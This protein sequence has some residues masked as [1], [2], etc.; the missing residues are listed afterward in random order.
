MTDS[1][2]SMFLQQQLNYCHMTLLTGEV[3]CRAAILYMNDIMSYVTMSPILASLL[4]NNY[5]VP[6]I[7]YV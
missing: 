5:Y 3:E 1:D 6:Y 4:H 2:I 7:I